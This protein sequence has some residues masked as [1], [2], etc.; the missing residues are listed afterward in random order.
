MNVNLLLLLTLLTMF[1]GLRARLARQRAELAVRAA[2][3]RRGGGPGGRL[4]LLSSLLLLVV[5]L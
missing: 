5:L 2:A 4:L 1:Q 3:G